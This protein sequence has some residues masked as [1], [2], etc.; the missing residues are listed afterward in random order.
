[1]NS[2]QTHLPTFVALIFWDDDVAAPGPASMGVISA[3]APDEGPS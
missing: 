3:S 2:L 1:M